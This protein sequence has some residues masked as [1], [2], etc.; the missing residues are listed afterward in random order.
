MDYKETKI[1]ERLQKIVADD[2]LYN[3]YRHIESQVGSSIKTIIDDLDDM[4]LR[5][6]VK[7][8]YSTL[9]YRLRR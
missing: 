1:M 7:N 6:Y 3:T 5:N 8:I 4:L 9:R 2:N